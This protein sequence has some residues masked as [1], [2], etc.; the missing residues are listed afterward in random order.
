MDISKICKRKGIRFN[1]M[2]KCQKI[3]LCGYYT[4]DIVNGQTMKTV[5]V[6]EKIIEQIGKE[7]ICTLDYSIWKKNPFIVLWRYITLFSRCEH[8]LVFP[9]ER[10]IYFIVPLGNILKKIFHTSFYYV[11]IGGWLPN[12][13]KKHRFLNSQL[14]KLD[15]ICVETRKM[16]NELQ[17][18]GFENVFIFHNFKTCGTYFAK[19]H[20]TEVPIKLFYLARIEEKKGIID[21]IEVVEHLNHENHIPQLTLDIYGPIHPVFKEAFDNIVEKSGIEIQYKGCLAAEN[22]LNTICDY[23]LQVFPT[24]YFT[25]GLPGSILDSYYAGVPILTAS[26]DSAEEFIENGKTGFIYELGNPTDMKEKFEFLLGDPSKLDAMRENCIRMAE[27][28]SPKE[29]INDFLNR[30]NCR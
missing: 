9:D 24:L 11:V 28:Y 30:I 6:T 2:S 4:S 25:E 23:D 29:I 1:N 10:A 16:E 19:Y 15:G 18:L 27:K 8:I 21:L 22:I 13:V 7:K 26:W 20:K 14:K 17:T 12:F 3:G 5:A